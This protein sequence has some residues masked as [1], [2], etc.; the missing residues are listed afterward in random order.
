MLTTQNTKSRTPQGSCHMKYTNLRNEE[1]RNK[2][3]TP[4][5]LTTRPNTTRNLP[6]CNCRMQLV[7]SCMRHMQLQ[8][9]LVA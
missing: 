9:R 5:Y 7:F 2:P 3:S 1:K 8:I 4:R 6:F